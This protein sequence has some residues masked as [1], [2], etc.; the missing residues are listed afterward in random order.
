MEFGLKN[1]AWSPNEATL[2]GQTTGVVGDAY[3]IAV[4]V[5][6][7]YAVVQ[8]MADGKAAFLVKAD[9]NVWLI[10]VK[11]NNRPVEWSVKFR[12]PAPR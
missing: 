11:G 2:K 1:V 12:P 4:Y 7:G 9:Q 3:H 10:P 8:G 5:P 6:A